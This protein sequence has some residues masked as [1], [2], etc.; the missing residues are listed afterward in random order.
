M[1]VEPPI[2]NP[3]VTP[4]EAI[5]GVL[6]LQMPPVVGSVN[7]VELPEQTRS[8]PAIG[9]GAGLMVTRYVVRQPAPNE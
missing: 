2:T 5:V 6:L 4:I 8:V 9:A 3:V 1:P 7:V